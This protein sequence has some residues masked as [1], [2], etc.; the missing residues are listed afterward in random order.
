[1]AEPPSIG[2]DGNLLHQREFDAAV[3]RGMK[4]ESYEKDERGEKSR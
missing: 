3:Q 2:R 1:L 4:E